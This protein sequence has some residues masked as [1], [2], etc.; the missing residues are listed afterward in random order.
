MHQ[1]LPI[2]PFHASPASGARRRLLLL[3]YHFPPGQA[4]GALRWQK[5]SRV[6]AERGWALDVVTLSPESLRSRDPA[7]LKDLAP[8]IR[9]YGVPQT[10]LVRERVERWAWQLYRRFKRTRK[11]APAPHPAHPA[12]SSAPPA[13]G[14]RSS[15]A[16]AKRAYYALLETARDRRWALAASALARELGRRNDYS[17]LITCGPP[18]MIHWAGERTAASLGIPFAMDLRDPWSQV[19]R[20]SDHFNS[21]L[22]YVRAARYE[23]RAVAGA[24]LIVM[25]SEPARAAMS[26]AYPAAA[27]R[28]I[29]VMNGFDEVEPALARTPSG[30]FLMVFAGSISLD[31]NPGSLLRAAARLVGTLGLSPDQFRLEFVG[32]VGS[33]DPADPASIAAHARALGIADFVSVGGF[34]PRGE[35]A[36]LLARATVLVSLYQDSRT[37]IPSKIFEYMQQDAWILTFAEPESATELLLRGSDADVLPPDDDEALI[38][39]L[40]RRYRQFAAGERPARL[41]RNPEFSRRTQATRLFDRLDSLLPAPGAEAH[42]GQPVLAR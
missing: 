18:H 13:V 34:R 33:L 32:N 23:N 3:T 20:L 19:E 37:A 30:R 22:W 40:T 38:A 9:V 21:P 5:M 29:T 25:N 4:V 41:A 28:I 31:R 1:S 42:A 2:E 12:A 10:E 36:E 27:G 17:A 24:G 6:A 35:L 26:R 7:G 15:I 14:A 16:D 39:T 11:S 8:G